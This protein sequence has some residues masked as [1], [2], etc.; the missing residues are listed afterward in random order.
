KSAKPGAG[1]ASPH[2]G[3]ASYRSPNGMTDDKKHLQSKVDLQV[4]R[5]K[6]AEKHQATWFASTIYLGSLG[7]VFI[8]PVIF[9]AYLGSWLDKQLAE[10][11]VGWTTSLVIVG[12]FIG[13]M[14]V[15]LM[16]RGGE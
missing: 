10:Y 14:N 1:N 6:D 16:I 5:I 9:G 13:G 15:Y 7:I 4:E 8:L 12:V 2:L 3:N 11:S